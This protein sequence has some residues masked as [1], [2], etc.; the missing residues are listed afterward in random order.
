[1]LH[2]ICTQNV[3]E[4]EKLGKTKDYEGETF[5]LRRSKPL[6]MLIV[7]LLFSP[8][9]HSFYNTQKWDVRCVAQ[10]TMQTFQ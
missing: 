9:I 7:R 4:G 1:M 3:T 5:N 6:V 8:V 10:D 2:W